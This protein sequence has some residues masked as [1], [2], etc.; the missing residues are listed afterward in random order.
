M[1]DYGLKEYRS[2]KVLQT[3]RVELEQLYAYLKKRCFLGNET[4]IQG[5]IGDLLLKYSDKTDSLGL[6]PVNCNCCWN[7]AYGMFQITYNM[8]GQGNLYKGKSA[9]NPKVAFMLRD[10]VLD[11]NPTLPV[12]VDVSAY[13]DD[14]S[15]CGHLVFVV[16]PNREKITDIGRWVKGTCKSNPIK[17]LDKI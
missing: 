1:T 3:L 15:T 12:K 17:G 5:P 2:D 16:W 9:F 13:F 11:F 14:Y 4:G 6:R 7:I 10:A 8:Y